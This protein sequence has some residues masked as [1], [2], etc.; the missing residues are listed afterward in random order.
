MFFHIHSNHTL[1][2][3]SIA[4]EVF[5]SLGYDQRGEWISCEPMRAKVILEKI[6]EA[7]DLIEYDALEYSERID[8]ITTRVCEQLN[9]SVPVT[10]TK[11]QENEKRERVEKRLLK[12]KH[13]KRKI[14]N[15]WHQLK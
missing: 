6:G 2:L 14:M 3:E 4:F 12:E 9:V 13:A 11:R 10:F 5:R 7:D 8:A 15:L 1:E